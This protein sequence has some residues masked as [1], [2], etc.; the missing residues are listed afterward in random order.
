MNEYDY[1]D[2]ILDREQE[3]VREIDLLPTLWSPEGPAKKQGIF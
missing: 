2:E 1:D 3:E